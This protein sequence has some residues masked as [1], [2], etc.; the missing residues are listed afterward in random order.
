MSRPWVGQSVNPVQKHTLHLSEIIS[1]L[2]FALDL[3]E[4]AVAG[5]AVRSCL[6]GMRIAERAGLPPT[7]LHELYYALLL[8]DIGCSS[9]AARMCQ[10]VGGDDRAVKAG[11]KL[12]DWTKPHRPD[13]TV[14]KLFWEQVLPGAGAIAKVS[15][16]A[17]IAL[18]QHRNNEEMIT[19]RCDSGAGI[20]RKIGLPEATAACVRSLDEHW[21]GSGYPARLRGPAIPLFS[22]IAAI[23]QHLDVFACEKGTG[24]A[25]HVLEQRSGQWFDPELVR[26]AVSLNH[27]QRLWHHCLPG[28]PESRKAVLDLEPG[29]RMVL[30]DPQIDRICEAFADVVDAKSPFTY[31]HSLGV[32]DAARSIARTLGLPT[33]RIKVVHRAAL[34]HDVGKLR[35]PN[36]ILDKPG[37]LTKDEFTVVQEHPGLTRKILERVS[38]FGELAVIAG[39]HHERLDGTGYPNHLSGEQ[40]SLESRILEVADMYGALSE[41][42]PYRAGLDLDEIRRIMGQDIPRRLDGACFEALLQGISRQLPAAPAV[43]NRA[44]LPTPKMVDQAQARPAMA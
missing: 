28:A 25:I 34:L 18:T 44:V 42:R 15:R 39:D 20:I 36:S 41:E 14:L 26:I 12:L 13:L 33:D 22:R 27:E 31:R 6:L 9:N 43:E 40:L 16:I 11:V 2:S 17:S 23:A 7:D 35:V 3:T 24:N 29:S 32:A 19:L 1:A 5:H 21:N 4:G 30:D 10:I 38:V 8:K 37:P